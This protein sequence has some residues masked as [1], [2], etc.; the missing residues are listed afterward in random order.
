MQ[1]LLKN[2]KAFIVLRK[3]REVAVGCLPNYG[4]TAILLK[5][6][7]DAMGGDNAPKEVILGALEAR[8]KFGIDIVLIGKEDV[9]RPYIKPSFKSVEIID[10]RE[11][12]TNDERPVT[13]IRRK[14][15]SSIVK[16]L[17]LIREG[18]AQAL[19]SAGSTGALMAGG[20]FIMGR[21]KGIDRPAI[22][23]VI[24][25]AKHPVLLL[26]LGANSEVKPKNLVQ[27]AMMGNI[28]AREIL[29]RQNPRIGLLNIG[30]EEEKGNSTIRAAYEELKIAKD[31]NF[32]GNVEARSFFDG[33]ADVVVCDG[34]S[35]NIFLKTIEGFGR[36]ILSSLKA[37][38]KNKWTYGLG[39]ML[40][41]PA[42]KDIKAGMDYSEY[43][44]AMFLGLDGVLIKCHGSSDRKAITNG[45]KA[46]KKFAESNI[47]PKL[48]QSLEEA[49]RR[50]D[51]S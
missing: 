20:L 48:K 17:R 38:V 33:N 22:A 40:L 18:K 45:I 32:I 37:E 12:I 44:G 4:A 28:Y 1:V 43:G 8:D 51:E 46:A 5:V 15:D 9:I 3:G 50:G 36:Y 29:N 39:A 23:S 13:A 11:I 21:L 10:A 16:G 6:L 19:V 30:T 31:I 41:K 14:K 2:V 35:G 42:I 24:P 26:D 27:F 34:F 47:G 7:V 49:K 25:T